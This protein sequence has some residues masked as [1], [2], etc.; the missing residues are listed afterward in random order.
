MNMK[1]A[2][3]TV[4][5]GIALAA[6]YDPAYI[7]DGCGSINSVGDYV[8]PV[9]C[10]SSNTDPFAYSPCPFGDGWY[11][12]DSFYDVDDGYVNVTG[13]NSSDFAQAYIH[14]YCL[15]EAPYDEGK[16]HYSKESDAWYCKDDGPNGP[17]DMV[18]IDAGCPQAQPKYCSD[19]NDSKNFDGSYFNNTDPCPWGNGWYCDDGDDVSGFEEMYFEVGFIRQGC[20]TGIHYDDEYEAWYCNTTVTEP[21]Q[22]LAITR[23]LRGNRE[24][25]Q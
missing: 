20:E 23:S 4:G 24:H 9:Y 8:S 6:D 11:C 21:S 22:V 13:M 3:S 18:W 19:D 17:V 2:I 15:S 10:N 25:Q 16:V 12:V 14:Q 7:H 5:V 1:L